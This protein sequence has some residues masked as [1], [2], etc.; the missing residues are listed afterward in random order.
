MTS[1]T[2]TTTAM[3]MAECT[4][5]GCNPTGNMDIERDEGG[6]RGRCMLVTMNKKT[7][8]SVEIDGTTY[9]CGSAEDTIRLLK[10]FGRVISIGDVYKSLKMAP[11]SR[12]KLR[13]RLDGAIIQKIPRS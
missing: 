9:F 4:A 2:T 13:E 8:F 3:N 12:Y 11:H 7:R 5:V 1:T 10:H 6:R